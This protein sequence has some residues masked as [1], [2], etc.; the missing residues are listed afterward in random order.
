M[1]PLSWDL[2]EIKNH[3]QV[4]WI[5]TDD[6]RK[7][8]GKPR[9]RLNPVTETLIFMTMP[10]RL[11]SITQANADDFYARVKIMEKLDGPFLHGFRDGKRQDR[12]FTPQDIQAHIGLG[13]NVTSESFAKFLGVI[14]DE[15]RQHRN[16]YKRALRE[17]DS[18]SA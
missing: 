13:C 2:S 12:F 16:S 9:F 5:E 10:V 1:S 17:K 3:E 11:G 4:C 7:A 14:R 8:N 15:H 6:E 18:V